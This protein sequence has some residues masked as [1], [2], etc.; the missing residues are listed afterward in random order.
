MVCPK[1]RLH[2][3]IF[4]LAV[5]SHFS[6][7][8]T[9]ADSLRYNKNALLAHPGTAFDYIT[10]ST[11]FEYKLNQ[12]IWNS[13]IASYVR[14]GVGYYNLTQYSPGTGGTFIKAEYGLIIGP[15]THH[16]DL[17]LGANY[18]FTGELK[19]YFPIYPSIA[20]R[21]ERIGGQ[22]IYRAGFSFPDAIFIGLGYSF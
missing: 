2:I 11:Y 5:S 21:F 18:I 17:G 15:R 16:L 9:K 4:L 12:G 13:R 19:S 22:W 8:Q 3:L 1:I 20:Y 6:S 14:F 7:A 10:F